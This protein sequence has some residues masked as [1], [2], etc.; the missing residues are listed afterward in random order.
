MQPIFSTT[1][2]KVAQPKL[3]TFS[4]TIMISYK[5]W[6]IFTILSISKASSFEVK[7]NKDNKKTVEAE[8]EPSEE[9]LTQKLRTWIEGIINGSV[10]RYCKGAYEEYVPSSELLVQNVPCHARNAIKRYGFFSDQIANCHKEMAQR[11]RL[12]GRETATRAYFI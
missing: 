6:I 9:D 3:L 7:L 2:S 10:P 12:S 5:V 1:E 4:G 8:K 11:P